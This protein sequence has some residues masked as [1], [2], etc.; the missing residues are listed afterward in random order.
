MAAY[1]LVACTSLIR[2]DT[3]RYTPESLSFIRDTLGSACKDTINTILRP[4]L[5]APASPTH[6][7]APLPAST[8]VPL[9]PFIIIR[10]HPSGRMIGDVQI[11]QPVHPDIPADEVKASFAGRRSQVVSPADQTWEVGYN[12]SPEWTGQGIAGKAVDCLIEG[13]MQ[14]VGIGTLMVVSQFRGQ[15][16]GQVLIVQGAQVANTNSTGLIKSRGFVHTETFMEAWPKDK[17]GGEREMAHY[18]LDLSRHKPRL[19]PL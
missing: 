4:L 11:F 7:L 6:P 5:R 17:G 16:F 15:D 9:F 3:S 19:P 13:W 12:L 8:P 18:E 10:H 2:A 14:W 1:C